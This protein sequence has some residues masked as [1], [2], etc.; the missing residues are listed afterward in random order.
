[1]APCMMCRRLVRASASARPARFTASVIG[2]KGSSRRADGC[3]AFFEP[4]GKALV[5]V[6]V[7]WVLAQPGIT[8]AIVGASRPEQLND[9]LAAVSL[10]LD[11]QEQEACNLA[12]FSLPRPV[13]PPR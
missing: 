7:A 5:P 1:M 10:K 6:G 11:P 13:K 12:W 9:S 4:P 2:S 3:R 8:W